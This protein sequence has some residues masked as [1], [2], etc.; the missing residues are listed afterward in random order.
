MGTSSYCGSQSGGQASRTGCAAPPGTAPTLGIKSPAG[1][2]PGAQALSL[3]CDLVPSLGP[4]FSH[5]H[6]EGV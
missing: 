6:N 1:R 5:L 4:Q 3:K 2:R